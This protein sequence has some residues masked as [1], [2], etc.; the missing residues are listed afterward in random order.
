MENNKHLK[1][2]KKKKQK[3]NVKISKIKNKFKEMQKLKK[4]RNS[5][6]VLKFSMKYKKFFIKKNNLTNFQNK[7]MFI[8]KIFTKKYFFI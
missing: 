8:Q 6:K 7:E 1:G 5:K 2:T 4:Y 3:L